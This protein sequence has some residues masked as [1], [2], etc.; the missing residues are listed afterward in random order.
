MWA[1]AVFALSALLF[2]IGVGVGLVWFFAGRN[3]GPGRA[4]LAVAMPFGFAALPVVGIV[5]VLLAAAAF[6]KND[7]EL[8]QE[9][10]ATGTTVP[11]ESMLFDEFGRGRSREIYMRIYPDDA[12]RTFLE[13]LP[14]LKASGMTLDEFVGRGEQHGFMWWISTAPNAF[15]RCSSP[16]ILEADGLNGWREFRLADCDPS[17]ESPRSG[18]GGPIYVIARGRVD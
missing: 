3:R 10:F 16:R 14:G 5:A 2:V 18:G 7:L 15:G 12:E 9:V 17:H 8:Y 13:S 1:L 6:Q 11:M 4:I